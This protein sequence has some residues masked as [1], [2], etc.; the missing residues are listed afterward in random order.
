MPRY[1][2]CLCVGCGDGAIG[3]CYGACHHPC[4]PLGHDRH[5]DC[6]VFYNRT[7]RR[8]SEEDGNGGGKLC[9]GAL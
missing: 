3:G 4:M 5:F 6:A 2:P 7:N 9:Q 8:P 1:D